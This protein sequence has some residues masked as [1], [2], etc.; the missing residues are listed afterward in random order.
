M[1]QEVRINVQKRFVSS[2]LRSGGT[3]PAVIVE[4]DGH[5]RR[6]TCCGGPYIAA[7]ADFLRSAATRGFWYEN[8]NGLAEMRAS[9]TMGASPALPYC[10]RGSKPSLRRRYRDP[11]NG[12]KPCA[13]AAHPAFRI[14]DALL[15]KLRR[16][17]AFSISARLGFRGKQ[18]P[19]L[20]WH[21]VLP[22][23]RRP[24]R[25]WIISAGRGTRLVYKRL[26]EWRR[27]AAW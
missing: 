18:V 13:H 4:A 8:S 24:W 20:L 1:F 12:P 15:S 19:R 7:R 22:A 16:V 9:R 2:C 25:R 27:W 23:A 3:R 10:L 17:I 14:S 21:T 5:W 6:K 26:A 11:P